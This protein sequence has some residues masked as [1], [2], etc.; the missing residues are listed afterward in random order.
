MFPC[1]G[2]DLAMAFCFN[3]KEF[4]SII[5]AHEAKSSDRTSQRTACPKFLL[6][7]FIIDTS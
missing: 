3:L 1:S 7:P 5:F 4:S 6:A 2:R